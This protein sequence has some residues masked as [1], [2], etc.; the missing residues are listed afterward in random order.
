MNQNFC[1]I[2]LHISFPGIF[3]NHKCWFLFDIHQCQFI[4][5]LQCLISNR[6]R[7]LS[8]SIDLTLDDYLLPSN[9]D[10]RIIRDNDIIFV[11]SASHD[12]ENVKDMETQLKTKKYELKRIKMKGR[13]KGNIVDPLP[14]IDPKF[15]P[16][17]GAV[18]QTN[19]DRVHIHFD[20]DDSDENTHHQANDS[21]S[22][23]VTLCDKQKDYLGLADLITLPN[24]EDKI[25]FK[26]IELSQNYTPVLSSYKEGIVAALNSADNTLTIKLSNDTIEL[27]KLKA[28][29]QQN[30]KFALTDSTPFE[31]VIEELLE[32]S[33]NDLIEPKKLD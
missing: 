12:S 29:Q 21:S 24:V 1:R 17:K 7:L 31:P 11:T 27:E 4:S 6:F 13:T 16:N 23:N 3:T 14:K 19:T 26:M 10:I 28:K 8:S 32:M 30:G 25:A 22:L 15:K 20:S 2:K 18:S 9:E 33:F 5:D